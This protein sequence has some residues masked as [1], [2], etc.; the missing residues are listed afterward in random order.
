M[1]KNVMIG[2]MMLGTAAA[3]LAQ[4]KPTATRTGELQVGG[5]FSNANPGTDTVPNRINGG[6]AYFDFDFYHRLGIEGSFRFMKDGTTN[7]YEKTYEVGPRYSRVYK[8][9]YVPY[10]KGLYGRGVFNFAQNGQTT[11]N[12]AYNMWAVGGG[13]DYRLLPYL[14]LRGDFEYQHW[15]SFPLNGLTP[16]VFTIGAAYHFGGGRLA[17]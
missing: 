9:K 1:F 17:R 16:T 4:A 14:N 12:I 6:T 8:D 10:V 5:G 13:L 3:A 7:I 15:L 11:A 2:L